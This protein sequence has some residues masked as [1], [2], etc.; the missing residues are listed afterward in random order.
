M[1]LYPIIATRFFI[2]FVQSAMTSVFR[3]LVRTV[4]TRVQVTLQ[5]RMCVLMLL[6]MM[7]RGE[8]FPCKTAAFFFFF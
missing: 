7:T 2:N 1:L 4:F 3:G 5:H 8:S 6:S